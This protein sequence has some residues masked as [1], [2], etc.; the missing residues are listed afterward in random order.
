MR[1]GSVILLLLLTLACNFP[2]LPDFDQ[3]DD[4]FPTETPTIALS[5][6]EGTAE[7]QPG[8]TEP[9]VEPSPVSTA[10][11]TPT[12]TS[13]PTLIPTS[14]DTPESGPPLTFQDPGWELVEWHKLPDTGEWEGTIRLRVEG[15]TPPYLSQ[16]DDKDIV[17]GLEVTAR[18]RLCK[19]MPATGRVWSA[20]GQQAE[21]AIWVGELGCE[22]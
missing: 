15:G 18:W 13:T 7:P 22:D 14:T 1:K 3:V 20:D 10:T 12:L 5:G 2:G 6:E 9:G 11:P 4:L 8:S 17:E 16:L 19:P 21:T